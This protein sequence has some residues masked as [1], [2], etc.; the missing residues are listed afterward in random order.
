MKRSAVFFDRDNTLIANDGYLGDPARVQLIA[1]AADAI[2]RCRSLGYAIVTVSNQSGVARG[3]FDEEAVRA[4][5]ARM[6]ELLK[7]ANTG[8]IIDRHE[9]CPFHP[10]AKL[11]Q[12]REDSPLRKPKPGMILAAA[13]ALALDLSRSWL[14]GDAPRDIAAGKA[15]G[16][17]TILFCDPDLPPSPATEGETAAPEYTVALLSEAIDYIERNPTPPPAAKPAATNPAT[18]PRLAIAKTATGPAPAKA[19]GS[20]A[21]PS[22]GSKPSTPQA[23]AKVAMKPAGAPA[24][25]PDLSAASF[26]KLESLVEQ[27][28]VELR[29]RG[30]FHRDDFSVSKLL[31][32]IVQVLVLACLFLGYLQA[33]GDVA[34]LQIYLLVAVTLQTMTIALLIMSRQK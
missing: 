31:A 29:R 14:I 15:A 24:A 28:L 34:W 12:Y 32:G 9:S 30:D 33:R 21:T 10:E 23:G 16:C 13:D 4:V 19:A 26:S 8:A 1:G 18:A 20:A 6:D 27:I 3:M 5:D 7:A 25:K 2:A 11:E 17:R 22:T